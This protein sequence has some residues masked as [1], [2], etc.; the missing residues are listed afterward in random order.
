MN[1]ISYHANLMPVF[2]LVPTEAI[3]SV[4]L[5]PIDTVQH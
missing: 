2:N 3:D 5:E 1:K 4:T